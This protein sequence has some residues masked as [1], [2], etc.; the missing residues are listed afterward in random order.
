MGSINLTCVNG[1]TV[2]FSTEITIFID[3]A[4][5]NNGQPT[6]SAGIGI[7]IAPHSIWYVSVASPEN[8]YPPNEKAEIYAA[9]GIT[10]SFAVCFEINHIGNSLVTDSDDL[11]KAVTNY[12]HTWRNN[13]WKGGNGRLRKCVP[14]Y[15]IGSEME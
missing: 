11:S 15:A 14:F 1:G 7:Y 9:I 10:M 6:A 13:G 8:I 12:A 3:G 4:C 5:I 2:G